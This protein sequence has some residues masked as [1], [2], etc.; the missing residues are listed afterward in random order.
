MSDVYIYRVGHEVRDDARR[1][2]YIKVATCDETAARLNL[3]ALGKGTYIVC[4]H[5]A[6]PA[7]YHAVV[8]M[9]DGTVYRGGVL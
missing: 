1:R 2:T 6:D 8:V 9:R 4:P 3:Q 7:D 5:G